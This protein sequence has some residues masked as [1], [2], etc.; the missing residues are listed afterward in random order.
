MLYVVHIVW[1]V[2]ISTVI[3]IS[4][5]VLVYISTVITIS[6]HVFYLC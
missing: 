2:Y 3:T 6:L 5:H 4:L 1:L